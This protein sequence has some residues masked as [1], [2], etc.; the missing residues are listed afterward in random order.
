MQPNYIPQE[1]AFELDWSDRKA[2]QKLYGKTAAE[3]MPE[4]AEDTVFQSTVGPRSLLTG[5]RGLRAQRCTTHVT[6]G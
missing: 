1:P 2:I 5:K 6:Q 3:G 4:L